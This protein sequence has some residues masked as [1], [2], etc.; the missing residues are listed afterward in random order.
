MESPPN[1]APFKSAKLEVLQ[2]ITRQAEL[3]IQSQ[4]AAAVAADQRA[5]A[6]TAVTLA[7]VVLLAGATYSLLIQTTPEL[8]LAMI[9][10]G[11]AGLLFISSWLASQAARSV[12]FDF[13]GSEPG[14]WCA[15]VAEGKD[16]IASLA[17]QCANYQDTISKNRHT[18]E[19]NGNLFNLAVNIALGATGLAGILFL[20]RLANRFPFSG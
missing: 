9:S 8:A 4:L 3:H 7:S 12:G 16:L 5:Y 2:E 15:D 19:A 10:G 14:A 1:F 20:A 11:L 6:F 18:M 13:A 17:E